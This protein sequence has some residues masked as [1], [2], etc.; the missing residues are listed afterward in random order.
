MDGNFTPSMPQEECFVSVV[1]TEA[2][3]L[4]FVLAQIQGLQCIAVMLVMFS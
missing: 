4:R 1:S 3:R 2:V